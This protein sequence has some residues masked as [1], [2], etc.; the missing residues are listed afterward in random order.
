MDERHMGLYQLFRICSDK[1]NNPQIR[2]MPVCTGDR[3]WDPSEHGGD[4]AKNPPRYSMCYHERLQPY[5]KKYCGPDWTFF[6]WPTANIRSF[7]DLKRKIMAASEVS[8]VDNRVGW[9]G[10]LTSPM[11]DVSEYYTRPKL[12]RIGDAHPDLFD[13]HHVGVVD[14]YVD[15]RCKGYLSLPEMVAQYAY[16][17]DIGGNGYSGRLKYLLF[18]RRP[19]ILVA[20]DF[21]EYFHHQLVPYKHYV[22][23]KKDLSDLVEKAEWMRTHPEECRAMADT[24]LTFALEEFQMEKIID[25]IFS[26][27]QALHSIE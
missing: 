14:N 12:K 10:N 7:E 18:S 27:F 3:G 26:V 23:V 13:I 11:S 4:P 21:V 17:L 15:E 19:L 16:V 24:A 20:R 8:P 22:P 5:N 25:R 1:Y 2:L 9:F 6:H